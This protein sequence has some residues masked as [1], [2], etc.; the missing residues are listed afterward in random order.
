MNA[1][2][3]EELNPNVDTA[4]KETEAT[5]EVESMEQ[6]LRSEMLYLR[7][8]FENTKRRLM[9]DQE[10]SIRFANEKIVGDLLSVVDL[11]ER[12]LNSGQGLRNSESNEVKAFVT[13]IEMTHRELV[14]LFTRFGA[15][16][17]G[18][19]GEKF[20]PNLHEAV[21]QSPAETEQVDCIIAVAQ[22]GC[23]LQGRLL[24]PAKVVVGVAKN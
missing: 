24:K 10:N 11:F 13:G 6:K 23:M 21:A 20:N 9:R 8:D 5:G 12:A 2:E 3:K 1:E 18:T 4:S 17:I 19:V 14:H 22:K 15:E 16:L 7:A